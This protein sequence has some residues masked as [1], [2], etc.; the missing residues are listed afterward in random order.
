MASGYSGKTIIPLRPLIPAAADDDHR[1]LQFPGLVLRFIILGAE[2]TGQEGHYF[3]LDRISEYIRRRM[4]SAV[5]VDCLSISSSSLL[6]KWKRCGTTSIRFSVDMEEQRRQRHGWQAAGHYAAL[7]CM[8]IAPSYTLRYY[9]VRRNADE[10]ALK[11]RM[12]LSGFEDLFDGRRVLKSDLCMPFTLCHIFIGVFSVQ[13]QQRQRSS[14]IRRTR[15]SQNDR[16]KFREE[17]FILIHLPVL[18]SL[19]A[20]FMEET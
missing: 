5:V 17:L 9:G 3:Q 14:W 20:I 6:H 13:Q 2:W 11:Q 1:H 8:Q 12:Q 19:W 4:R 7:N 18:Q 16:L 10:P 15:I